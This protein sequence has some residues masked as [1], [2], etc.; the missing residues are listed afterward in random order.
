[1][2]LFFVLS[3]EPPKLQPLP[4]VVVVGPASAASPSDATT[5]THRKGLNSKGKG[6]HHA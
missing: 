6:M 1:M 2:L 4:P 5:P 3:V